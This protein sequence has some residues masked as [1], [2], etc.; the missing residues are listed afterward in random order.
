MQGEAR[1][2]TKRY[3]KSLETQDSYDA[4]LDFCKLVFA[5]RDE[6]QGR[7]CDGR[8][9]SKAYKRIRTFLQDP[10]TLD[11]YMERGLA[12]PSTWDRS[13]RRMLR[14]N[15]A[16]LQALSEC[17]EFAKL[18]QEGAI[19]QKIQP[20]LLHLVE[21]FEPSHFAKLS[22][23][24]LSSLELIFAA[25]LNFVMPDAAESSA[26][27]LGESGLL[28]RIRIH[29]PW[30]TALVQTDVGQATMV[31]NTFKYAAYLM[32]LV[33]ARLTGV[34]TLGHVVSWLQ[35]MVLW[36]AKAESTNVEVERVF[37]DLLLKLFCRLGGLLQTLSLDTQHLPEKLAR[38]APARALAQKMVDDKSRSKDSR[39][40]AREFLDTVKNAQALC[41]SAPGSGGP[42]DAG[43]KKQA[44]AALLNEWSE[45]KGTGQG[46]G[47]IDNRGAGDVI[48]VDGCFLG[49]WDEAEQ[50]AGP[51]AWEHV[52]REIKSGDEHAMR[53]LLPRLARFCADARADREGGSAPAGFVPPPRAFAESLM[54]LLES[55]KCA[56]LLQEPGALGTFFLVLHVAICPPGKW[57]RGSENREQEDFHMAI[58][59]RL[60]NWLRPRVNILCLQS[61]VMATCLLEDVFNV[62]WAAKEYA[63][64]EAGYLEYG[65]LLFDLLRETTVTTSAG[66]NF[67]LWSAA[68]TYM[69]EVI[70]RWPSK[71]REF[72]MLEFCFRVK[73]LGDLAMERGL[74]DWAVAQSDVIRLIEGH[75]LQELVTCTLEKVSNS[76][77]GRAKYDA[78]ETAVEAVV[79]AAKFALLNMPRVASAALIDHIRCN[80]QC[81][82]TQL[83]ACW[84]L[85][86]SPATP[87]KVEARWRKFLA[88]GGLSLLKQ[89]LAKRELIAKLGAENLTVSKVSLSFS[90][91]A[92][93][94]LWQRAADEAGLRRCSNL[95]RTMKHTS[96][97]LSRI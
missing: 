68:I 3:R 88:V 22:T 44:H 17:R 21:W 66:S 80:L 1:R 39:K 57:A 77:L 61:L 13:S 43:V 76:E 60:L 27:C 71:E 31:T 63:I 69:S 36:L 5:V 47:L 89:V 84:N 9:P 90:L 55:G 59:S 70:R 12:L 95:V 19:L 8:E 40:C 94:K 37:E 91:E 18:L 73:F 86:T 20:L 48:G 35:D 52:V 78:S 15:L 30:K 79:G 49:T 56:G 34:F 50:T 74:L 46:D 29:L 62:T 38:V 96:C 32:T 33:T 41:P 28:V 7:S 45:I 67:T 23:L 51:F 14:R 97:P 25:L 85:L 75:E 4:T 6:A 2:I 10:H 42:S 11:L 81:I 93:D 64:V 16:T 24:E 72:Q 65:Y 83:L 58:G 26:K 87:E 92:A 54:V 82:G 53:G